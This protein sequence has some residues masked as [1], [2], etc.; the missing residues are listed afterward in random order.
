MA[1]NVDAERREEAEIANFISGDSGPLI[2]SVPIFRAGNYSHKG[3][4][5][6]SEKDLQEVA[7]NFQTLKAANEHVPPIKSTHEPDNRGLPVVGWIENVVAK[8]KDLFADFRLV[9]DKAADMIKA[10]A[11]RFRSAELHTKDRPWVRPDGTRMANVLRAVAFVPIPEVKGMPDIEFQFA[12]FAEAGDDYVALNYQ[13]DI[14]P[15]KWRHLKT[16]E[17]RTQDMGDNKDWVMFEE[18]D[19]EAEAGQAAAAEGG[20]APATETETPAAAPAAN[21][22]DKPAA[23]PEPEAH[24]DKPADADPAAEPEKAADDKEDETC[25]QEDV[26]IECPECGKKIKIPD[27]GGPC[28]ECKAELTAAAVKKAAEAVK[29]ADAKPEDAKPEADMAAGK[30][31]EKPSEN[32][33]KPKVPFAGAG[34]VLTFDEARAAVADMDVEALRDQVANAYMET[35]KAKAEF[36]E[37]WTDRMIADG[38]MTPAQRDRAAVLAGPGCDAGSLSFGDEKET[39]AESFRRY[40]EAG[41]KVIDFG[42]IA[43]QRGPDAGSRQSAVAM[44]D[45]QVKAEIERIK[46]GEAPK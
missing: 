22:E 14:M 29:A 1:L 3:K 35:H 37:T 27:A 44:S 24:A 4:G 40:V 8:G 9:S 19:A 32:Y 28:P 41:A 13:E 21:P 34:Q 25:M 11:L 20:E 10:K 30:D 23:E 5:A 45:E 46:K 31:G 43:T 6:W 38:K 33:G 18:K 12:S 15:K 26:E 17:I 36:A 2:K 16:G 42:E 7:Q 39:F